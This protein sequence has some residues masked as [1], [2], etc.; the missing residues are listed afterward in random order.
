LVFAAA[1]AAC[2]AA[3]GG[4]APRVV[5]VPRPGAAEVE[6]ARRDLAAAPAVVST[7]T[8][9]SAD[10]RLARVA[11]RVSDAAQP[12]CQAQ[13]GRGCP[14]VVVLDPD[15]KA[16]QASATGLG[17]I[18]VSA[19]MVRLLPEDDALAAVVAH[20]AGHHLAGHIGRQFARGTLAG[21]A[22][23]AAL[24]AVIPFGG[25]AAW[26]LGQGV[27]QLGAEAARRAFSKEEER[28]ADAIAAR[29]VARAGYDPVRAERLWLALGRGR[30]GRE[31]GPLDSHPAD[32]ERLAAWRRA[33][34]EMRAPPEPVPRRVAA[35]GAG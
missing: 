28:E 32:A 18:R 10:Q 35:G 6:A 15:E 20:E 16:A 27:A 4:C 31:A 23:S 3:G 33:V 2:L 34:E 14:L 11:R 26:A 19:G 8:E 7:A 17:R 30:E 5:A 12:L 25:V 22:A 9:E 24:G 1:A 13:L 29:I 21:T